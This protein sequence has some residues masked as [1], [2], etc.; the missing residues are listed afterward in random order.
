MRTMTIIERSTETLGDPTHGV[1]VGENF[2]YLANSGW[3]TIDDRGNLNPGAHPSA[4]AIMRT[5]VK[6]LQNR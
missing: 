4:A 2:Y 6:T 5:P 1:I 3:D